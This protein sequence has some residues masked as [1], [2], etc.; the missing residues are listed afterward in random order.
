MRSSS[1]GISPGPHGKRS[2]KPQR[3]SHPG[4]AVG[5][6]AR[7]KEGSPLLVRV[8][9]DLVAEAARVDLPGLK[10]GIGKIPVVSLSSGGDPAPACFYY[11]GGEP[12]GS[13]E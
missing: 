5:I 4:S 9:D 7:I 11:H 13:T 6:S 8:P 12:C 10:E 3:N 2:G 1:Y